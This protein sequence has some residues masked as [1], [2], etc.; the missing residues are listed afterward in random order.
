MV[1]GDKKPYL[2]ALIKLKKD[3]I[4]VNA[5][6]PKTVIKTAAVQN[7]LG[8]VNDS[9][10]F[11]TSRVFSTYTNEGLALLA[12]GN[13]PQEIESA[14]KKAGMPVGPLAVIDEINLGLVDI[15]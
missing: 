12:E 8:G 6:W 15:K 1:Y 3:G 9:R 5:L 13:H 2:T 7:L 11:Y 4:G 10:G 14:G